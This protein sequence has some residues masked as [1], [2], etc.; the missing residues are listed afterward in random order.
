VVLVLLGLEGVVEEVQKFATFGIA[1]Q[2]LLPLHSTPRHFQ[3]FVK[4]LLRSVID[5]VQVEAQWLLGLLDLWEVVWRFDHNT[6][7]LAEN[8][9]LSEIHQ[10]MTL[11]WHSLKDE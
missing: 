7:L 10:R 3:L 5:F 11:T 9:A 8:E 1:S 2:K 6:E 4:N